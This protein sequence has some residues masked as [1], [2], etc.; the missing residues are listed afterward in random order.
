MRERAFQEEGAEDAKPLKWERRVK[1][2]EA[3][4]GLA[5]LAQRIEWIERWSSDWEG[6]RI[7]SRVRSGSKACTPVAVLWP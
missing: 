3:A 2:K 1:R 7:G 6:F 4:W 5:G